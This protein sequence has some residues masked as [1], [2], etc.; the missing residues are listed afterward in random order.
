MAYI[1]FD[2]INMDKDVVS[3]DCAEDFI[4][5]VYE[6]KE[7]YPKSFVGWRNVSIENLTD[8]YNKK[9]K[10]G[11]V[12]IRMDMNGAGYAT[13]AF[14]KFQQNKNVVPYSEL[15]TPDGYIEESDMNFDALLGC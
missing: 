4:D 14:Y 8:V 6:G 15:V 5:F 11:K 7:R 3:F 13:Y 12:C 10:D 2:R 9:I 1:D